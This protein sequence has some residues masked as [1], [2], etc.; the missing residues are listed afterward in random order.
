MQR[1]NKRTRLFVVIPFIIACLF[2]AGAALADWP[3]QQKITA[4][5]AADYDYFGFSVSIDGEYAI[6]GARYSDVGIDPYDNRG[7][8]YVFKRTGSSW[9]QQDKLLASDGASGDNFGTSVS[10]SGDY[11]IISA[12]GDDSSKGSAYIFKRSGTTWTQQAKLT[13][14]DGLAGDNFGFSVS[15][16]GDYAIV[17]AYF[18][19]DSA[20]G[21]DCGS[22][23]VFEKP[24]GEWADTNDSQ[25][26]LSLNPMSG[27]RFGCAVSID[28]NFA[29]V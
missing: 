8:A 18:D 23:Y 28:A 16:S 9:S 10:I 27:E 29:V 1:R 25:K 15:L 26:I 19:D 21:N 6:A 3:E 13:A 7:A 4:S 5:D 12:L 17:G 14:F 24:E 2:Q 11:A 20:I 22:A